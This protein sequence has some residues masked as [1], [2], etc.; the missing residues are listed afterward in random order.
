MPKKFKFYMP[1]EELP[2]FTCNVVS[3]TCK[4]KKKN[5]ENC[6]NKTQMSLP[7]C[8]QHLLSEKKL[9]IKESSIPGAGKGLFA[10]DKNA[11]DDAIIFH[12]ND[13]IVDYVGEKINQETLNNRYGQYT[14]PYAL[15]TKVSNP[16][17]YI[18]PACV[19]GVGAMA[20]QG[21]RKKDNN[22]VL[23]AYKGD[24]YVKAI[25]PIRNNREIFVD[26][27][28]EYQFDEGTR[29]TTK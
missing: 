1:D 10:V 16:K 23:K 12:T 9:R 4:S 5:G 7:Y 15:E 11:D 17:A 8:W 20:N 6:R 2:H 19:R 18:D 14:A 24:G 28:A 26:Y 25:K 21:T 29:H 13:R 22:A 3:V 27:G